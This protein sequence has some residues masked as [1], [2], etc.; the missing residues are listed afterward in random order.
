MTQR[1]IDNK[2]IGEFIGLTDNHR[3]KFDISMDYLLDVIRKIE[4]HPNSTKFGIVTL[5]G[6][7]RTSI[8]CYDNNQ[9]GGQLL[10]TI[11]ILDEPYGIKPTYKA[12]LEY[13]KYMNNDR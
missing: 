3:V 1:D 2:L 11:D 4:L 12:I 13:I 6:L 9:N 7:S 10:H 5:H 8:Q